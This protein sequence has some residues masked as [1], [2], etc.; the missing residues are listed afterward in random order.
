MIYFFDFCEIKFCVFVI[1]WIE[2]N[3]L[4]LDIIIECFVLK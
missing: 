4:K 1:S 2:K 3:N